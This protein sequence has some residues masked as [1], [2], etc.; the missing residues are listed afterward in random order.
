MAVAALN[1]E[2]LVSAKGFIAIH[3][4]RATDDVPSVPM[5]TLAAEQLSGVGFWGGVGLAAAIATALS[6]AAST[7]TAIW[8]RY[9]DRT[10]AEWSIRLVQRGGRD[11]GGRKVAAPK[12]AV[13]LQNIGDGT[14]H[15]VR[16][17]GELLTKDPW[18]AEGDMTGSGGYR[19]LHQPIAVLRTGE[20]IYVI[21]NAESFDVWDKASIQISW[22]P[23]P[24][25]KKKDWGVRSRQQHRRFPLV[26]IT[27]P[28]SDLPELREGEHL[29]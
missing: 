21:A 25:R 2:I 12:V 1:D 16:V 17:S 4:E 5:I 28:P 27:P 24:T 13:I 15:Q 23:P 9:Q 3:H 10:E 14:A 20:S 18:T 29:F 26:E 8:W 22:W 7:A 19:Q 11:G 6:T